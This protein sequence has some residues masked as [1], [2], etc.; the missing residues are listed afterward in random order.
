MARIKQAAP[1]VLI[2]ALIACVVG[3]VVGSTRSLQQQEAKASESTK[4]EQATKTGTPTTYVALQ[5]P[6]ASRTAST[7][8][9]DVYY[10]GT[11]DL[12]RTRC[13]S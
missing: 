9:R 3:Y 1:S 4:V 12:G 6:K 10:P 13:A 7:S 5:T 8:Y 11:E 2:V